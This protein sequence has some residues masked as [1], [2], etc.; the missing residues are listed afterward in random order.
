MD[1]LPQMNL[2]GRA[3]PS[4]K[5]D[6]ALPKGLTPLPGITGPEAPDKKP[7]PLVQPPPWLQDPLQNSS[8]PARQY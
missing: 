4:L 6:I 7:A 3:V 2:A 8:L 5:H 1:P